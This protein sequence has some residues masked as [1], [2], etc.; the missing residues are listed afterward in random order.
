MYT[1]IGLCVAYAIAFDLVSIFQCRPIKGA[2]HRWDGTP[3]QCSNENAQGWASAAI[4]M[5][6]DV[7]TLILPL[8]V[9]AKLPMS[10]RKKAQAMLMFLVGS[11]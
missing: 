3:Y 6:L 7:T 8:P 10:R 1:V 2:W 5:A 11:L 4:N 9:L